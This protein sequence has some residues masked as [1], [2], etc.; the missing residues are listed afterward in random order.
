MLETHLITL[1]G[2]VFLLLIIFD[3]LRQNLK[4]M[5]EIPKTMRL[6]TTDKLVRY[7]I[8][9]NTSIETRRVLS[10]NSVP[11]MLALHLLF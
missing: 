3:L 2:I 1:I 10:E 9:L 6:V 8:M 5:R 4:H 7:I 11:L